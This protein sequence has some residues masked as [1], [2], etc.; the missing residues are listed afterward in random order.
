[1]RILKNIILLTSLLLFSCIKNDIPYPVVELNIVR[2][3]GEGFVCEESDIDVKNSQV[4]IHLDETTDIS[5][6]KIN[7]II[8]NDSKG[9][10]SVQTPDVFDMRTQLDVVLSLYQDY[11]WTIRAVQ[12]IE[13]EFVVEGQIGE[14]EI[15]PK[16]YT[17]TAYV[18][19][20]V[21]LNNVNIQKL[22]LGPENITT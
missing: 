15:D 14:S 12:H 6:V 17:A 8:L 13:R 21:D 16:N 11:E 22:K 4:T 2:V 7:R 19:D 20:W 10:V 1:M 5:K 9:K 18:P 3:E